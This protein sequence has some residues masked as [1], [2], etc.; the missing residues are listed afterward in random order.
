MNMKKGIHMSKDALRVV[1]A[2][3]VLS[4]VLGLGAC[5]NMA[6]HSPHNAHH[7]NHG[8]Q[9]SETA[10]RQ[11]IAVDRSMVYSYHLGADAH[12]QPYLLIVLNNRG[13]AVLN[14]T[15]KRGQPYDITL[16]GRT[17]AQTA[18]VN[19]GFLVLNPADAAWT[20]QSLTRLLK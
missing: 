1:A 15:A 16:D 8:D 13:V 19:T 9:A 7:A 18:Q 3:G 4:V 17:Y 5:Q 14:E 20:E 10:V 6:Q 2:A 12:A 11:S